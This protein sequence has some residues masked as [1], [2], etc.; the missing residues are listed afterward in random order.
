MIGRYSGYGKGWIDYIKAMTQTD[1]IKLQEALGMVK[2]MGIVKPEDGIAIH[3]AWPEQTEAMKEAF[4]DGVAVLNKT[5]WNIK[6]GR[7]KKT[8]GL[9]VFCN[10]FM[11]INLPAVAFWN[12][13]KSCKYLLIQDIIKRDRG[14]EIFGSDGDCMR[15]K[16]GELKSNYT[17][18]FDIGK[19]GKVIRFIPYEDDR[20]NIHFIALMEKF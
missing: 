2:E 18:A 14:P 19:A 5:D 17:N 1:L 6:H 4:G 12:V 3:S 15:Y 8:F 10:V 20:V 11:Y 13:L 7:L 16:F 9:L